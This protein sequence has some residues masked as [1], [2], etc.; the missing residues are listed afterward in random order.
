MEAEPH[1][2][3][4]HTL[5]GYSWSDVTSSLLR[6]VANADMARAQRWSAELVC[7]E[8]GLGR[9]EATLLHAWSLHV[10]SGLPTWP[11]MWYNTI[12]QLR[13]FWSKSGEDIKVVRNTPAVR[14]LVA[15]AVATLVLAAKKP[16]P[17]LPTSADCFKEAEAMRARL[18][19]GGGAGD[20]PATRRVW[21]AHMDGMDLRTVGNEMEAALR[22][23]QIS[24][25]LFWIIWIITLETQTD[26]PT[27][28]ERGP[29]H[30]T[31]KQ[32]KSILWYL[33]AILK[34]LANEGAFLSVE[35][36]NGLF[37]CL[38]LT[39]NKQGAKGRRDS[40]AAIALAIQEHLQRR[41]SLSLSGPSAPPPLSAV[42]A[43]T[44]TID[45]IYSGIATEARKFMLEVPKIVGLTKEA[46]EA[47]R[48][49]P[50]LAA[51][52]KLAM[53]YSL[54]GYR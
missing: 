47:I 20:Q 53:A 38:E 16:L 44:A 32:R 40:L 22:S 28:K 10:G 3:T 13:S 33:V 34:E 5:C 9:L 31:V 36:R 30:L 37:G 46:A 27:A 7:S 54:A 41:G 29:A 21:T 52:D 42:R 43:A 23:N 51:M 8:L 24:R 15:E 39:W 1:A 19:S 18:R 45:N 2:T 25:L 11:R 26:A 4:K 12:H 14:Q 35:E 17:I 49:P 50:K 48:A 6:A